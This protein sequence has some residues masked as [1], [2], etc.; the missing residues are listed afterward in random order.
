MVSDGP[1]DRRLRR[2][3]RDRAATR[4]D[5]ADYLPRLIGEELLDRLDLVRRPFADALILGNGD[6]PV[7]GRLAERG[8]RV[9]AADAGF[10][11]ARATGGVQCDED[12]LPFA[13]DAFDLVISAGGLDSVN[14]LPGA[15]ILI[16]RILRPDGLFLAAF[17]GAG[18]LPCLKRAMLA[19]DLA[20]G[21]AVSARVHPQI[22][23][24][25]A[26]DLLARA[27]FTLPVVDG[28][29]LDVR[30][31]SLAPLVADLR[32]WGTTNI[33]LS[34]P[35]TL[36]RAGY[37]AAVAE[38]AAQAD[39]DGKT[40]ERIEILFATAWAPSPDQPKPARRGSGTRSL[41]DALRPPPEH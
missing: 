29:G 35:P 37:A 4:S 41:A 36:S 38:F 28:H 1:F 31:P 18:S 30:F 15:L 20:T 33:L 7:A 24:R 23:V 16:R 32:D 21:P 13:D 39:A 2:L 34:R 10:R 3:R 6:G 17:A 27:G 19:A 11:F 26:G 12:R 8:L 40:A 9:T 5:S 22:D 25:A 14:D